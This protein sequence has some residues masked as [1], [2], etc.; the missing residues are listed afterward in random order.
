MRRE[1]GEREGG[2]E[3]GEAKVRRER[4]GERGSEGAGR[5]EGKVTSIL[6]LVLRLWNVW[7]VLRWMLTSSSNPACT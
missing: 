5:L 2:E 1:E 3:Q 7:C 4:E 6:H